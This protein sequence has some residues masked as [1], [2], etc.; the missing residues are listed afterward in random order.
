MNLKKVLLAFSLLTVTVLCGKEDANIESFLRKHLEEDSTALMTVLSNDYKRVFNPVYFTQNY[1]GL[2]FKLRPTFKLQSWHDTSLMQRISSD[3]KLLRSDSTKTRVNYIYGMD[4]EHSFRADYAG[5]VGQTYMSMNFDRV[6]SVSRFANSSSKFV[7]FKVNIHENEGRL[8]Q[9]YGIEKNDFVIGENGGVKDTASYNEALEISVFDIPVNLNS[10]QN[11]ASMLKVYLSNSLVLNY[12]DTSDTSV[13]DFII[14][15]YKHSLGYQIS[16]NKDQ[17]VYS[18]DRADIDSSYFDTTVVNLEET[19]DSTGFM[20]GNYQISYQ[21]LDTLNREVFKIGYSSDVYNWEALNVSR[22]M[23]NYSIF[24]KGLFSFKAHYNLSGIWKDGYNTSVSHDYSLGRDWLSGINYE[25]DYNLPAYFFLN[26][27]GNHFSW[28]N[29]FKKVRNQSIKLKLLNKKMGLG[30][31][32]DAHLLNDWVYLDSMSVPTQSGDQIQYFDVS[33]YNVIQN[34][35]IRVYTK[36]NY[37][38]TNSDILRFPELTF[39]NVF[40]YYF[41]IGKLNFTAGYL[42]SYFTKHYGL[43]YNPNLRRTYLQNNFEVGGIPIVDVF[44]SVRIGEVDI[45]VK[46]ENL[47]FESVSRDYYLYPVNPII[48]RMIRVGVNWDFKN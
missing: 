8:H 23:L 2:R 32:F 1:G 17:Y 6:S 7:K 22:V 19:R 35:H 29:S 36:V 9:A 43:N 45:F 40:N 30:V 4:D 3:S 14:P 24:S 28:L 10:A 37:Q 48:P 33:L 20:M 25:M 39:R 34:K 42:F 15:K 21:L 13:V 38:R 5:K 11:V 31:D 46:G 47:L 16:G 41:R 27:K 26:Y 12:V 44:A 18:M